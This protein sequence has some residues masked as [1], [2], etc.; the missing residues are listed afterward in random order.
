MEVCLVVK[1]PGGGRVSWLWASTPRPGRRITS[2][3]SVHLVQRTGTCLTLWVVVPVVWGPVFL[4]VISPSA[5]GYSSLDKI[6]W[7]GVIYLG[8]GLS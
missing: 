8:S 6:D 2:P 5:M 4:W 1:T 3:S 7:S